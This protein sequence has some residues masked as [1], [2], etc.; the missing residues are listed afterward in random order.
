MNRVNVPTS[1]VTFV[2]TEHGRLRRKQR[3]I[4]KKDLQAARKHGVREGAHPRTNGDRTSKYTHKDIV[5]IVNEV[6]GEEVTSYAIPIKLDPVQISEE[7]K[8]KHREDKR[9]LKANLQLWTSN[10]VLVVDRS[11]SMKSSDMWDSKNRLGSVWISIALDFLAHRL[12]S[13]AGCETDVIS[14]VTLEETPVVLFKEQSCSWVLYNKLVTLY[15]N[16]MISPRGHGPFLPC[17]EKAEELLLRNSYASCAMALCF[18]SDGKPSDAA[19]N[20]TM[21]LPIEYFEGLIVERVASLAK[22][23]GRRLTFTAIGIGDI[24]DF[25]T[26]EKMVEAAKDY[27]AISSFQLPSMSSSSLGVSFTSVATS[28]T[29]TQVEMTDVTTLKQRKVRDVE[30]ESRKRANQRLRHVSSDEFFIYPMNKVKRKVYTEHFNDER[31]LVKKYEEAPLQHPDA[32]Y[33]ALC[34]GTFGEGAER[35]AF[36]FFEIASDARTILGPPLVAKES[37]L[38]LEEG[39]GDETSRKEFVR[40]FCSTQQLARRIAEEFNDKLETTRRVDKGTPRIAFLDCSVYQL[41]DKYLGESSV[42]VEEKLD[43]EKWHKWNANNG[44]VEGMKSAPVM[45]EMS[46]RDTMAKMA[47]QD[48]MAIVEGGS[49]EEEESDDDDELAAPSMQPICFTASEVAQAFSHFSY[50]ATGRKRLICD[51]QGIF[52]EEANVLKLSDP[53]IH[54]YHSGRSDRR[55]VHGRTDRGRKGMAMFFETHHEHCGHLCKLVNRGFRRPRH[56]RQAGSNQSG[57]HGR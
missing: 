17:L 12:E 2:E 24:E 3:G 31:Q 7:A 1:A 15:N 37:R 52:D 8:W 39:V 23:F 34:R 36:R 11:G 13:G 50:L 26:L 56:H 33:V 18:L 19:V 48:L 43:H 51:L 25:S 55:F 4:D 44:F 41:R 22:K 16:E 30:R 20:R 10:T 47:Q 9:K 45:C 32:R 29:T 54:Y 5:Y 27:G 49:E 21:R 40:T 14:I 28:L 53:V 35:I 6:T 42:L 46:I 38:V 57:T